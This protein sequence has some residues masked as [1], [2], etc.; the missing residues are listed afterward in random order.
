LSIFAV[1]GIISVSIEFVILLFQFPEK[2]QFFESTSRG[3]VR[4][5]CMF[6]E[7]WLVRT[8]IDSC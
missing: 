7:C 3:F 6:Q 4:R 1:E 8:V 2:E 5:F